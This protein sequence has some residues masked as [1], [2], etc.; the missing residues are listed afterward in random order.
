[1]S[2]VRHLCSFEFVNDFWVTSLE[3]KLRHCHLCLALSLSATMVFEKVM[4]MVN[5]MSEVAWWT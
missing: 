5:V 3:L 4:V 2:Q 1:M